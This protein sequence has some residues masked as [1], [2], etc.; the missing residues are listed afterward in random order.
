MIF[1]KLRKN[2]RLIEVQGI[3]CKKVVNSGIVGV[4]LK[5]TFLFFAF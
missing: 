5:L 3:K 2:R 1:V 4:K